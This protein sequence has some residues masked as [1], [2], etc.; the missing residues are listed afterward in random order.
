MVRRAFARRLQSLADTRTRSGPLSGPSARP[1]RRFATSA[2]IILAG[3]GAHAATC[4]IV[5]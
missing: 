5:K 3:T 4:E 2:T 1:G